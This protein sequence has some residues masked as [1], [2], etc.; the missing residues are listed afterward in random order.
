MLIIVAADVQRGEEVGEEAEDVDYCQFIRGVRLQRKKEW[1]DAN[2]KTLM[3]FRH[4]CWKPEGGTVAGSRREAQSHF[5]VTL[6]TPAQNK[7]S[8][9]T[10]E[11]SRSGMDRTQCRDV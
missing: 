7:P 2:T 5:T 3:S 9:R 10:V 11:N 6:L 4:G 8:C 1:H